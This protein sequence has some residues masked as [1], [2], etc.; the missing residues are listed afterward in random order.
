M[1]NNPYRSLKKGLTHWLTK[2]LKK[3]K[4][5]LSDFDRI[6]HELKIGDVIL[7]EGSSRVSRLIRNLTHSSWT[8]SALYIG[9]LHDIEDISL[10]KILAKHLENHN[11]RQD[12]PLI[13]EGM[14]GEGTIAVP[15]DRYQDF[16]IRLCRPKG[17]SH[18]DAQK[19][20]GVAVKALG[21][22]YYMRQIFD[23]WRFLLPWRILPRRWISTLFDNNPESRGEI[24]S[25]LIAKAFMEI[26]FPILPQIHVDET[27]GKLNVQQSNP[28][29]FTPSDFDY[30][31]Y[32]EIIKYPMF[33]TT[34]KPGCR[35]L[36]WEE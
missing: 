10:R 1:I 29:L 11:K 24:C 27:T 26:Q 32:F 12:A 21:A 18:S 34:Q 13:I 35:E 3:P 20:I 22:K 8:H 19:V 25:S 6:Q 17:L 33:S 15:L 9:H 14:M 36:P 16:H 4:Y 2:E 28:R 31:P 30:S 5:P 7:I 23:L